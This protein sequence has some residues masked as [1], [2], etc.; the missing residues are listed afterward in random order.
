MTLIF[1][2]KNSFQMFKL[3]YSNKRSVS[4]SATHVGSK[5]RK[6]LKNWQNFLIQRLHMMYR[7]RKSKIYSC[8]LLNCMKLLLLLGDWIIFSLVYS[9]KSL[10][11]RDLL[12]LCQMFDATLCPNNNC[13][14]SEARWSLIIHSISKKILL[15]DL[16]T[17]A[18]TLVSKAKKLWIREISCVK[19]F[20]RTF[21]NYAWDMDWFV[22]K[23]QFSLK[24][25][26]TDQA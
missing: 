10:I 2:E 26:N 20:Y 24:S 5:V 18:L 3:K 16:C 25:L 17:N 9:S 4:L 11:P 13:F 23:S 19:I 8:S 14:F 12:T 6:S 21:N 15:G 7:I 1:I 22:F